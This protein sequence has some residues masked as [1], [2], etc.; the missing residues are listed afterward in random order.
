MWNDIRQGITNNGDDIGGCQAIRMIGNGKWLTMKD[1]RQYKMTDKELQTIPDN[2]GMTNKMENDWK[3]RMTRVDARQWGMTE[4][5]E[6]MTMEHV[7]RQRRMSDNREWKTMGNDIHWG[8]R[9]WL[10]LD[11]GENRQEGIIMQN[12]RQ[13]ECYTTGNN[14]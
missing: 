9:Q 12:S 3:Y 13:W 10:M 2:W 11:N 4:N 8:M 14:Q 1:D 5:V 6:W 7:S